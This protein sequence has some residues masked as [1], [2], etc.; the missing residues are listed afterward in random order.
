MSREHGRGSIVSFVVVGVLLVTLVLGGL[1]V[2]KNGTGGLLDQIGSGSGDDTKEVANNDSDNTDDKNSGSNDE[3]GA[4]DKDADKDE[5]P[6]PSDEPTA[7]PEDEESVADETPAV[8]EEEASEPEEV[9]VAGEGDDQAPLPT[10]G[11]ELPQTGLGD[12]L[13][14]TLPVV[15]LVA[16][17]VAYRRSNML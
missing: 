8:T 9:A 4:A 6:A 5:A 14:A 11:V 17:A 7:T 2:A 10:T 13:F 3:G 1:Y 16:T 12:S 15:L